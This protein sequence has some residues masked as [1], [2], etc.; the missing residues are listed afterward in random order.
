MMPTCSAFPAL[1]RHPSLAATRW[2]GNRRGQ[3]V[4]QPSL[5]RVR[6]HRALPRAA[7]AERLCVSL[8]SDLRDKSSRSDVPPELAAFRVRQRLAGRQRPDSALLLETSAWRHHA[9][10]LEPA[11]LSCHEYPPAS[12]KVGLAGMAARSK[13]RC[14]A[15]R[16]GCVCWQTPPPTDAADAAA[17]AAVPRLSSAQL[18]VLYRAGRLQRESKLGGQSRIDVHRRASSGV[19]RHRQLAAI[20]SNTPSRPNQRAPAEAASDDSAHTDASGRA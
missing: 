5:H 17:I 1:I 14:S 12:S 19:H 6:R 15:S 11:D 2:S 7:I 10:K 16:H 9:H 8:A 20:G 4:T 13:P 18:K 3:T